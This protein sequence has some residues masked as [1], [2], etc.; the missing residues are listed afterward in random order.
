MKIDFEIPILEDLDSVFSAGCWAHCCAVH[1][2][3]GQDEF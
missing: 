2:G 1:V 3:W